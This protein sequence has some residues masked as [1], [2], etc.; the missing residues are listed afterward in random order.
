M[1]KN[2]AGMILRFVSVFFAVIFLL[3]GALA[4]A[5]CV[6]YKDYVTFEADVVSAYNEPLSTES[7]EYY[8]DIS[9]TYNGVKYTTSQQGMSK[10]LCFSYLQVYSGLSPS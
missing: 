3:F 10:C 8:V 9:Y 5:E 7:T 2:L 6:K 1:F 4:A